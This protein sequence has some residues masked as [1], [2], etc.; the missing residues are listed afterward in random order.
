MLEFQVICPEMLIGKVIGE[1]NREAAG[2]CDRLPPVLNAPNLP[3][4]ATW[5]CAQQPCRF[6]NMTFPMH[7]IHLFVLLTL[8]SLLEESLLEIVLF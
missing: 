1:G 3:L 8:D 6:T 4:H 5:G 7:H 2:P